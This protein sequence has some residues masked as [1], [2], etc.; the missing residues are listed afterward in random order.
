MPNPG[1]PT[2]YK[3][4]YS[5]EDFL[6]GYIKACL[7][8]KMLVSLCGLACYVNVCEDTL[9]EWGKV[10]PKFSVSMAKINQIS[11][12][13]L[14]NKGLISEYS[15]NMARF[16]LSANHGMAERTETKHDITEATATLLG[17]IDG[18]SKGKLPTDKE[19]ESE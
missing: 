6:D 13:M 18:S 2:K 14:L 17:L 4:E 7:R 15:P 1:R 5:T 16:V 12:N 8:K 19:L 10:H 9:Q 11:K 3:P